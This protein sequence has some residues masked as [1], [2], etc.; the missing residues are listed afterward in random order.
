MYLLI[1]HDFLTMW[2]DIQKWTAFIIN[3]YLFPSMKMQI[4]YIGNILYALIIPYANILWIYLWTKVILQNNICR[5]LSVNIE[6]H[7]YVCSLNVM[8][9]YVK[10]NYFYRF[11]TFDYNFLHGKQNWEIKCTVLK[12][13]K[14]RRVTKK[15][16][17]LFYRNDWSR[18]TLYIVIMVVKM[19]GIPFY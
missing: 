16:S 9:Y 1:L 8:V 12:G 13:R 2:T 14:L 11:V 17:K 6:S 4:T 19:T 15:L 5:I 18:V 10:Q 7:S 3:C